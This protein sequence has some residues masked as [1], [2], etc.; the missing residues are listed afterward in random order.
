MQKENILIFSG[1]GR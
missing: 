1:T